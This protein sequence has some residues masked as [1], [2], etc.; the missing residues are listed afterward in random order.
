[1]IPHLTRED[2]IRRYPMVSTPTLYDV[3][4]KLGHPGQAVDS[5]IRPLSP[6]PRLA[7]PALTVRGRE[8]AQTGT[9][10]GSAVS[11]DLF[12][13]IQPGDVIVFDCAGHTASGPWGGNTGANAKVRGAA[14]IVLDG[15]TRDQSDLLQMGFPTFC[16]GVTPVLAHGRFQIEALNGPIRLSSQTG[17]SVA[18]NPGDFIVADVDGIVVVPQALLT[19]VLV[20]AEF[21]EQAE[22]EIR[23]AIE[24]GE[25]R[26]AVDRRI[27]RWAPLK[28]RPQ[29]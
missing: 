26:E 14:G 29:P 4:A 3:L 7:G 23:R 19:E 1:M 27:D 8:L 15:F 25:D 5:A 6:G 16:R 21:A 28:T 12:R 24:A 2:L 18:V 20:Y 11:Y 10:W 13:A 9:K 17:G 22:G